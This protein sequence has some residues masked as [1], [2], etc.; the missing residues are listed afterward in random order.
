MPARRHAG[1]AYLWTLL[2]V[3]FMGIGLSIA[4]EL[5]STALRRDK[6]RELIFIGHEFRNA[7]GRYYEVKGAGGQAQY[8]L[9]L[10]DLLKDNRFA[11]P[12][13]H[14]R[15]LY[16]DP[17]TGQAAWGLVLQEGRIVGVHSLSQQQPI[18]QDNFLDGDTG[19]R[20]KARYAD[21][22]FTYPAD[23][24]IV[25]KDGGQAPPGGKMPSLPGS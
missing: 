17:T 3:A 8:P 9:T 15:R 7:I 10:E 14:L 12:K 2:L 4:S 22:V 21:W 25:Q 1:F 11:K 6:E 20:Q 13:R 23:L 5:Y 16:T 19:L 18:K 24:F